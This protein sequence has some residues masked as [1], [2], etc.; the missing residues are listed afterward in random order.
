M[1]ETSI[2]CKNSLLIK[3]TSQRICARFLIAYPYHNFTKQKSNGNTSELPLKV[4][5]RYSYNTF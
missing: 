2:Q 3:W 1:G 4:P 5:N